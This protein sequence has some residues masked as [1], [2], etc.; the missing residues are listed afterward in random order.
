MRWLL[1]TRHLCSLPDVLIINCC[2][3]RE[4]DLYYWY[5]DGDYTPTLDSGKPRL[6]TNGS[7]PASSGTQAVRNNWLPFRVEITV[8]PVNCS[9]TV[10]EVRPLYLILYM[11]LVV[12][13]A[14][15]GSA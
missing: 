9:V 11:V 6:S 12:P 7:K 4:T 14:R 10:I 13:N 15:S 5:A 8:D 1:Q 2:I 3:Q